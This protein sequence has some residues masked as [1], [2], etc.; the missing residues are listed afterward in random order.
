MG[1][2]R[3]RGFGRVCFLDLTGRDFCVETDE[4]RMKMQQ[5]IARGVVKSGQQVFF[6]YK[7]VWYMALVEKD[8]R[9]AMLEGDRKCTLICFLVLTIVAIGS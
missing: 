7:R 5:L 1:K 2:R 8:G 9:L 4:G 6:Q 3:K